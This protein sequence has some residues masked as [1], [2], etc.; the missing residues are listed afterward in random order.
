M[1][2][3]FPFSVRENGKEKETLDTSCDKIF[4]DVCERLFT[5]VRE[6]CLLLVDAQEA[7]NNN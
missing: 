4:F 6:Y 5:R 2:D 7:D 1:Y 3:F